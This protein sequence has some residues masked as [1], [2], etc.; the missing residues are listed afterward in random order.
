MR[1]NLFQ[2]KPKSLVSLSLF[3]FQES[4]MN[5]GSQHS[6]K[7][8][9]I[10]EEEK[11]VQCTIVIPIP[12]ATCCLGVAPVLCGGSPLFPPFP[13]ESSSSDSNSLSSGFRRWYLELSRGY[14]WGL[15]TKWGWKCIKLYRVTFWN[16]DIYWFGN[17]K[18]SILRGLW[19]WPI[20]KLWILEII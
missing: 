14:H 2:S 18:F 3:P 5:L 13:A 19:I 4:L 20:R 15:W 11:I 7:I 9:Y 17:S 8:F 12:W 16:C 1:N 10:F 6:F